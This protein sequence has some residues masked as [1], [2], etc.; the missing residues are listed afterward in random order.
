M[1]TRTADHWLP[2]GLC[3][4]LGTSVAAVLSLLDLLKLPDNLLLK[5]LNPLALPGKDLVPINAV[6][7]L[8]LAF[9][10]S[11]LLAV[12]VVHIPG[13]ARRLS[14]VAGVLVLSAGATVLLALFHTYL[15]PFAFLLA[16]LW[17]GICALYYAGSHPELSN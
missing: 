13:N 17:A 5:V 9:V 4:L 16:L 11:F 14:V 15:S 8:G 3:A 2:A 6:A 7:G 1:E 12:L 10:L